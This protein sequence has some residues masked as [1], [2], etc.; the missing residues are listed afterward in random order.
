MKTENNKLINSVNNDNSP[1][2]DPVKRKPGRPKKPDLVQA[3]TVTTC[4]PGK[5][6]TAAKMPAKTR[7]KTTNDNLPVQPVADLQQPKKRGRPKGSKN[8]VKRIS[9]PRP[10]QTIQAEPGENTK[11]I[12]HDM[13]LSAL[14]AIDIN[15]PE[16]MQQR[17]TDYFT[18]CSEDDIKPS[19]ASLGLAFGVSRITLFKW[20][21]GQA[22][23]ALANND[24][25]N[26]L[27]RAYDS[28]NSYYEHMM[29]NGRINPVAGI[30][31]MKNNMGYKDTTDY[32]ITAN[33]DN[34]ST[35]EDITN[36]AGLLD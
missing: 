29:N 7:A 20:V 28:I 3:Q 24:S 10:Q 17:I 18:I 5:R 19:V 35:I 16:Q 30:F 32:I 6:S 26:T 9:P 14:P 27:K 8:S 15:N 25:R 2:A 36:R 34:Q 33:T 31:L 1:V 4:K 21:N 11:Y 22:P 13:K 23:Q 12:L